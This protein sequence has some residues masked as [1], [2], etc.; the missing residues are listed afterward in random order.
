MGDDRSQGTESRKRPLERDEEVHGNGKRR[1]R[2]IAAAVRTPLLDLPVELLY[3][4]HLYAKNPAFTALNR[5]M[6]HIFTSCPV[7]IRAAYLVAR[8]HEA[9]CYGFQPL[10]KPSSRRKMT[11]KQGTKQPALPSTPTSDL[12]EGG[13]MAELEWSSR[14]LPVLPVSDFPYPLVN[15]LK[16]SA[17]HFVLDFCLRYP[18]CDC[19]VLNAV[20]RIVL[21]SAEFGNIV[22]ATGLWKDEGEQLCT[23]QAFFEDGEDR[24]GYQK[25]AHLMVNELPKRIF[26]Q[27]ASSA[28][29][30]QR[31]VEHFNE[32]FTQLDGG[33][34]QH[35]RTFGHGPIPNP[36]LLLL[37]LTIISLHVPTS[38]TFLS[39]THPVN[40]FEGLPL[41]K[42]AFAKSLFMVQILLC[43]GAEPSRMG[44]VA[45]YVA[46][47]SGWLEGLTAMVERDESK[48]AEWESALAGVRRWFCEGRKR[49]SPAR[50]AAEKDNDAHAVSESDASIIASS[51]DGTDGFKTKKRRRLL[52]RAHLDSKMLKEAVKHNK[53]HVANWLRS[54]GVIPDLRTI[55][56]IELKQGEA[57]TQ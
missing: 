28:T 9:Y 51:V 1:R 47:R 56:L 38:P 4:I 44:N 15:S 43:L 12:G 16:R 54:K 13:S 45:I 48:I 50:G 37:F 33:L 14:M 5:Q 42:S 8:W 10:P 30:K 19:Q 2:S 29:A 3:S 34:A 55:K 23:H 22:L 26:Q 57:V 18:I 27:L 6:Y 49:R 24:G 11:V 21:S 40:S 25:P 52:D 41:A 36:S 7:S 20:E 17:D 32:T 35:L 46:I 31:S 53:W 39:A